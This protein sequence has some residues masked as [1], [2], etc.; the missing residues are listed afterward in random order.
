MTGAMPV[1]QLLIG[2]VPGGYDAV[3]SLRIAGAVSSVVRLT[4]A[5]ASAENVTSCADSPPSRN[6]SP[7]CG[8]DSGAPEKSSL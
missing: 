7:S 4:T 6:S 1:G 8:S 5:L 2:C 3:P